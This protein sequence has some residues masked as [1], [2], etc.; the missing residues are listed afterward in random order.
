MAIRALQAHLESS[1]HAPAAAGLD[2]V[3]RLRVGDDALTFQVR[4]GSLRFDLPDTIGVDATFMFE[5]VDTAWSLLSGQADAFEA[6]MR[7]QFRSDG[8]LMW[9]FALMAMFQSRSLPVTPTE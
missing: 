5:D 4:G 7:G 8:Y 2:A 6:F 3:V 1:F 9:A